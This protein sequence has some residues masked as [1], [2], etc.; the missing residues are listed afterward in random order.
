MDMK[1]TIVG[2][3]SFVWSLGLCNQLI[4]SECLSDVGVMLMDVDP[5]GLDLVHQAAQICNRKKGSPIKIDKTPDLSKA[6]E[7]ADFVFVSIA[8]GG[9]DA[10]QHD[11]EI[12]ERYG[13]WH[14][15]G[16]TVGPGGWCRAVRNIP[17]FYNI[18]ARM[19]ELCPNAWFINVS[20][21]LTP[22]T[23]VPQRYFGIRTIGLCPG[24]EGQ[25][26]VLAKLAGYRDYW[27]LNYVVTGVDHGSW[28]L[29]L[30]VDD[31]DV[32][33]RLK[34]LGYCRADGVLPSDVMT[35][36]PL[37]ESAR[38][39][40]AFAVWREIGYL[41]S[42]PDRHIVE[43]LPWFVARPTPELPYRI[44]RTS[45]AE[46]RQWKADKKRQFEAVLNSGDET[47]LASFGHGDD[48]VVAVIEALCGKRSFD[49]SVNYM[50][51]GQI[52]DLPD[53]AVVETRACFDYAG[54]HP[55]CSPMPDV[56]KILTLPTVMRQE[57]IV[58]IALNGNF[59]DLVA[60]VLTD[61][62][63]S[64]MEIGQCR[65]MMREMLQA[66]RP[67]IRNPRLLES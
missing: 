31:K 32:L 44:K 57:A 35:D 67:L 45:V 24:V 1:I 54:V 9:L 15:V 14:T 30:R 43:F 41:P 60:L 64:H 56:L 2:G 51:I 20:N 46:R 33:A 59:D 10:M 28:L 5:T 34:E 66:D 18:A 63:C 16:D 11:L 13:I 49:Y 50:N 62:L 29:E 48:P 61:P 52:P 38:T 7:G 37:A 27:G 6:L 42:L 53:G 25:I 8:V 39:R 65:D 19:R 3:G 23:R 4:R 58:E 26:R 40:A 36:D 47:L 21:P 17:V 55:L 22:L 12:P